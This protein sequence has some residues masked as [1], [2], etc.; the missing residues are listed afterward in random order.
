LGKPESLAHA[1][2]VSTHGFVLAALEAHEIEEFILASGDLRVAHFAQSPIKIQGASP[3]MVPWED[4]VFGQVSDLASCGFA[5]G[6][7]LEDL[8]QT[9][10]WVQDPQ[11]NFDQGGLSRTVGA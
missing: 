4:E 2:G 1:F 5:T 8:C 11:E 3:R 9:I 10:R 6:R 7:F